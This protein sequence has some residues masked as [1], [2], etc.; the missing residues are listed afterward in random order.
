MDIAHRPFIHALAA[1]VG[2]IA[3]APAQRKRYNTDM[4]KKPKPPQPAPDIG[5]VFR[6]AEQYSIASNLLVHQSWGNGWG[7]GCPHLM[8]DSFAVELY[9]KCLV[10]ADTE[11]AAE[12]DHN[13]R[14]LFNVLKPS[15]RAVIIDAFQRLI[16]SDV[17]M[18]H[19]NEINPR[20]SMVLDFNRSL[21]AASDTFDGRRYA[22]DPPKDPNKEW[23]YGH[24]LRLAV[25]DVAKLDLRCANFVDPRAGHPPKSW[26]EPGPDVIPPEF[27]P[28]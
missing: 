23:Y 4:A 13:H 17:V 11:H 18:R 26:G 9:L 6:L 8:V 25:R 3:I 5:Q 22:Y 28:T 2:E 12:W 24:L 15:T 10:A 21:D 16:N 19:L 14:N 1:T 20:A 7:C 27:K